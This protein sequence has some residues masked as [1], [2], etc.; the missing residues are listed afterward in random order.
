MVEAQPVLPGIEDRIADAQRLGLKLGVASSSPRAWVTGHLERLGLLRHFH[1]VC[2]RD[3]ADVGALKPDPAVY[4][5]AL[6][7]LDVAPSEA[8]AFEDSPRG[9]EAATRAGVFTVAIPND[10]TLAW[11]TRRRLTLHSVADMTSTINA[12]RQARR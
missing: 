12:R 7:A 6:R 2:C 3:D 8:I 11:A 10:I 9:V 1:A 4:V 5:A